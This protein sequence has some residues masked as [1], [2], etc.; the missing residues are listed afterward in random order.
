MYS[1]LC[2]QDCPEGEVDFR[3]QQ[4]SEFNSVAFEN[5]F[6]KWVPYRKA[7]N[8]CELNCMPEG[9]RFYYRHKATV[10]DG[11][12]CNEET[13]DVCV[14]GACEKVGCDMML[15]STSKEDKCRR[16][17]GDGSA[18]RTVNGTLDMSTLQVGYN[19]ILLIPA[20]AT[21]ILIREVSPSNNYLA[22]RNLMGSY[23]LNGNWRIDFPS[24]KKFAGGIWHYERKPQG[25]AAP[26]HL[27]CLGP[28][29]EAVYVVLLSQDVNVGIEYEYSV[30]ESL[31]KQ[32]QVD[33]YYWTFNAYTECSSKCGGGFQTRKVS[34]NSRLTLEEVDA[35]LC[36][37]TERPEDARQCGHESCP[38][39]W[40][41][42]TW[43]KCSAVC[44]SEGK[45]GREVK[46][47]QVSEDGNVT[48]V[49]DSVC[50]DS[51]G[52]KPATEQECN[53]GVVCP[54][55]YTG[56][57]SSCSKLCGPGSQKREVICY[58]KE[59]GK[60]VVLDAEDCPGEKPEASRECT[61][62][63]CKGVDWITSS[64]SGVSVYVMVY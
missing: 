40:T 14:N 52:N 22:I 43:G 6:Y 10:I 51:V 41:E 35:E 28:T 36:D 26:D 23:Y 12:R 3:Q 49:K 50:L 15:G 62:R 16:C 37:E 18:C 32:S 5:V 45:Q 17:E 47:E 55:W 53:R 9:E 42:S 63:P 27:T 64:W 34:C 21:N 29:S 4:C 39:H 31:A 24:P 59:Q 58:R 46:C 61:I 1:P 60:V 13:L 57:W 7:P 56:G 44:G 25:F 8:P 33:T 20:G 11:T 2:K 30:L 48:V 54:E 38:P 19:D